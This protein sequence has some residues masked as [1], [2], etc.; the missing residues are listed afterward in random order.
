MKPTIN[1]QIAMY[2]NLLNEWYVAYAAYAKSMGLSNT[3]LDILTTIYE[4]PNCTQKDIAESCFLPKQTVNAVVTS[5]LKDGWVQLEELPS[6]RRNKTVNLT[7]EGLAKAREIMDKV[8]SCEITAMSQLTEDERDTLL[9]LTKTYIHKC[10][11]AM[12]ENIE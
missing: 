2:C 4:N 9:K 10:S 7:A 11:Q 1:D 12:A 3:A 5:F 6:D 8:H